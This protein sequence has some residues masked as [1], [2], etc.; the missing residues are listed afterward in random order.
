MDERVFVI[1]YHWK[2]DS[3]ILYV[4]SPGKNTPKRITCFQRSKIGPSASLLGPVLH[5]K[6]DSR[7]K[8][9]L[10]LEQFMGTIG[11]TIQHGVGLTHT[12]Q[13]LE[14]DQPVLWFMKIIIVIASLEHLLYTIAHT[15]LILTIHYPYLIHKE[16][17]AL[18]DWGISTPLHD[19]EVESDNK[20]W[21]AGYRLGLSNS[22]S[23][24]IS[25]VLGHQFSFLMVHWQVKTVAKLWEFWRTA[26]IDSLSV[27]LGFRT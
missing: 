22:K 15:Y 16:T 8:R 26:A 23:C 5:N 25:L 18:R 19:H 7:E 2:G 17:E 9:P 3:S 20:V 6:S 4:V 21:A 13:V 11:M 12:F 10:C 24:V 14:P 1:D 27:A